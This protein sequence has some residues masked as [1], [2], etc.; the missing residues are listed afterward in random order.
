MS[1]RCERRPHSTHIRPESFWRRGKHC[2]NSIYTTKLPSA[3]PNKTTSESDSIASY[4]ARRRIESLLHT[5]RGYT[6]DIETAEDSEAVAGPL[7]RAVAG[8][9]NV[10]HTHRCNAIVTSSP[11][12]I[13][14][15]FIR[16]QSDLSGTRSRTVYIH[17]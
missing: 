12:S 15:C 3:E 13:S 9:P 6:I 4:G 16:R 11:Y 7:E 10:T 8:R 1:Y 5:V 14:I 17:T 2:I